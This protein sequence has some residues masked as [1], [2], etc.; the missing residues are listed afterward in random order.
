MRDLARLSVA[1]LVACAATLGGSAFA[2]EHVTLRADVLLY[3][4]NT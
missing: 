4:D 3:G 1:A 2:Q